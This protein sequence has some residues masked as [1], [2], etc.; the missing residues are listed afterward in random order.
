ML[1]TFILL[2]LIKAQDDP[3][4]VWTDPNNSERKLDLN[5]IKGRVISG[6]ESSVNG[7][8]FNYTFTACSNDLQCVKNSTVT[9]PAMFLQINT[10]DI[11]NVTNLSFCAVVA[12]WDQGQTKPTYD[13]Q[14]KSWEFVYAN[15]KKHGC[16]SETMNIS[17]NRHL[18]LKIIC[19]SDLEE[20][21]FILEYVSETNQKCIYELILLSGAACIDDDGDD[22]GS[23]SVGSV[24]LIIFACGMILYCIVGC[25][26]TGCKKF[27]HQHFWEKLPAYIFAGFQVTRAAVCGTCGCD[28]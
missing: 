13:S 21:E 20:N 26:F 10:D 2:T 8:T 19:D 25:V 23:I 12:D 17:Y 9:L 18:Q 5:P 11:S 15:G 27:P 1:Y 16:F 4:C 22:V 3:N 6:T 7:P 24:F 28:K 14:T